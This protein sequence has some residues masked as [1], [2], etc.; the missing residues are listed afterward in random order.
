MFQGNMR[1]QILWE[2]LTISQPKAWMPSEIME[3]VLKKL[4]KRLVKEKRRILLL[5]DNAI[6]HYPEFVGKISNIKVI[7]LPANTTSKLQPLDAGIIK[8]FKL[9][10]RGALLRHVVSQLDFNS[11]K[12]FWNCTDS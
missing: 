9:L 6:P 10:Y 8:N 12:C 11:I 2:F 4:N 1:F 5:L 3:D 7:F